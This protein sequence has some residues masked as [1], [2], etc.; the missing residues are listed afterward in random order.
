MRAYD[1]ANLTYDTRDGALALPSASAGSAP[2]AS[3]GAAIRRFRTPLLRMWAG[4]VRSEMAEQGERLG[5]TQTE[6]EQCQ[7]QVEA[8][9]V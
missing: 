5:G 3:Y 4:T 9:R 8:S 7:A 2:P 6:H 1:G